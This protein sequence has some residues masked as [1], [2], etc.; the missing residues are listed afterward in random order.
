MQERVYEDQFVT[1]CK[2]LGFPCLK[3]RVDGQDGFP[4]RTVLTD[5]GACFVEF[6]R[7][8]QRLRP[9][10]RLFKNQIEHLGYSYCIA[11]CLDD[12]VQFL[13]LFLE[14]EIV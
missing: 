6:K 11:Y 5:G 3:L 9:Q 4:D 7:P 13:S 12:A 10:Q 1:H 8:G 2:S 14:G